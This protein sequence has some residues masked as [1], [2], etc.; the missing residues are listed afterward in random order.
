MTFMPAIAAL[1]LSR[2]ATKG[3]V[4]IP[5]SVIFTAVCVVVIVLDRMAVGYHAYLGDLSN[6][7]YK[8]GL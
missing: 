4:Y 2:W 7:K 1:I 3:A 5:S 6:P 8:R